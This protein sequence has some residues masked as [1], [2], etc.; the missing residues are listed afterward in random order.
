VFIGPTACEVSLIAVSFFFSSVDVLGNNPGQH[1]ECG[2]DPLF[3]VPTNPHV[4]SLLFQV[5]NSFLLS[6]SVFADFLRLV[7][8][9]RLEKGTRPAKEQ[10]IERTGLSKTR[11]RDDALASGFE[12][13]P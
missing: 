13:A 8:V 4:Y 5:E 12:D 11:R 1:L 9:A 6:R 3:R 7:S 10:A 2:R